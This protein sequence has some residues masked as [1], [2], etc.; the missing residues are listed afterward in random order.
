MYNNLNK[1]LQ[2]QIKRYFGSAGNVPEDL[3]G[4]LDD[5][6][7]TY[8]SRDED[9]RLFQNV[10]DVSSIE[11]RE[12]L[13][14]QRLDS[15]R[16]KQIILKIKEA[17]YTLNPLKQPV[18]AEQEDRDTSYLFDSLIGL[19]EEHKKMELSLIES[20]ARMRAITESAQDAILMMDTQGLV[21]FWNPSAERIFG[22]T[23][24]DAMGQ[25]LHDLIAPK[26]Y[27]QAHNAAFA[28][29]LK[30]GQ[31][32]AVNKLIELDACRKGGEELT[33]ELS[34]SAIHLE[35]GWHS[36]GILRDITE[37]KLAQ[38]AIQKSNKKWEAT[39]AA[40]PDGIGMISM[41]GNLQLMSDKMA[42][43]FGYNV[44]DKDQYIGKSIINFIDPSNHELLLR[45]IRKL[46]SEDSDHKI[47][48]YLA[49]RKDNSKFYIDVNS[50][51]LLDS[52]GQPESILFVGRDITERK[53]AELA[54]HESENMQRLLLD[55]LPV[56]VVII[57]PET[58]LIERVNDHVS[59]L[60]GAPAEYLV[61]Q[62]CNLLLC[63][64]GEGSCTVCDLCRDVDNSEKVMLLKD[65][66]RL[67]ILKTVKRVVL[68]GSEKLLECFVDVSI[69]KRAEYKLKESEANFRTFFESM[70]DIVMVGN[71]QGELFFTNRAATMKLGYSTG[72]LNKMNLFELYPIS[73]RS[74]ADQVF[75]E[76]LAGNKDISTL[77]LAKKDGST[78]LVETRVWFG[79]WDGKD[80]IFG[81]SKDITENKK[82][83]EDIKLQNDFYNV[84]STLSEKLIQADSDKLD[85]E[86]NNSLE[87][88]GLFNKVDK[89]YIFELNQP[90]DVMN[91]IFEWCAPG[92]EPSIEKLQNVQVT[93]FPDWK[94][95]F[96]N[97]EHIYIN[98]VS[99]LPEE[100]R[101][102]RE[103]LE[104]Q[105]VKSGGAV[106]MFYGSSLIGFIGFDSLFEEKQWKD[107]VITLLKIYANVLAG[108]INKKKTEATL[109]KA[110]QEAD[111]ASKAKSE[112]L[113][114]MSH[115]I[116]TPL[117]GIIGF[118]DL[119]MRTPLNVIQQQYAENV[120][121]SGHTLLGIINDILD[122]SKIEAGKMELELIKTDMIELIGQTSDI[123]KYHVSQKGIEFLLNIQPEMPRFAIIDP[124]RLK[125]ILINLLGNA[126][127]FTEA[128]E[129]ELMVSFIK[130]DDDTG[131]FTIHVRDTGIGIDAE[132]QK[133]LFRAFSQA[134]SSTTRKFGGTGLGLTI[135][136]M[137]AQK[138]GSIIEIISE[139]DKGSDFFFSIETAYEYGEKL[140][141]NSLSEIKSVMVI[142]DNDNNRLIL[143]HTFV[144]WGIKFIGFDNGLSAL[145]FIE[146]S[147]PLDVIIVDYHMPY[148]NGLETIGLIR[149]KLKLSPDQQPV[150]LLHSSADDLKIYE[151]CKKLG[152]KFN[153]TKPVKSQELLHYLKNIRLQSPSGEITKVKPL[154][155]EIVDISIDNAP[156]I[157]VVEDV[158]INMLLVTTSLK[159]F[160]PNVRILE[161]KNGKEAVV[162]ASS[163]KPDM[164]FMDIQM[165][166]MSGIEAT[167]EIRNF[168]KG[169][170]SHIPIVALTAGAIK[171]D[172]EKC[173]TAGMDDFMTK[174]IDQ[175]LMFSMLKKYLV[176]LSQENETT[177]QKEKGSNDHVH[178][179][180]VSL[181]ENIGNNR[182]L[183]KELIEI[184]PNQFSTDFTLLKRAID[185]NNK[186]EIKKVAH[187]LK[188]AAFSM[189]FNQLAQMT[190]EFEQD[191]NN[192]DVDGIS[193][194]YNSIMLEWEQIVMVLKELSL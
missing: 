150:V 134:D 153:L 83:E 70:D 151:E 95:A 43:I 177:G 162:T 135:S 120:N 124:Q 182:T 66:T 60:F 24:D 132:Q 163:R 38:E 97:N 64:T 35:G 34:L 140:D 54:L 17:I 154:I 18:P 143:E 53:Q 40:S 156:T 160:I 146:K 157:L 127:K 39:I 67:P 16:R 129:I 102:E 155:K 63:P 101:W 118:T 19:I 90:M 28:E 184:V 109:L 44:S 58:R 147:D 117:N 51:L 190:Q 144:N 56:G 100:R 130:K 79:Q 114:N 181:M 119:L 94:E 55:T 9:S 5:V 65:G 86:I 128:G 47:T 8:N 123:I 62:N 29:F 104:A 112:F 171:E 2:R 174:P 78:L 75:G 23:S 178:F 169:T 133:K 57:D 71:Q 14:I 30:T 6:S 189:C 141:G 26:H 125:Q 193:E 183:L 50:S 82:L 115:E 45:N 149:D 105:L 108:V 192:Y 89:A 103:I 52:K 142:D 139:P 61:G 31:G 96:L 84:I 22:Y 113:A 74:E 20:E 92:I 172:K 187:S 27:H 7:E 12:A 10:L 13:A 21:S 98:K 121:T 188:G 32:N 68:N 93:F 176:V 36:I 25:N 11:L 46:L 49:I 73:L 41:D 159:Q 185:L 87:K 180:L 161:A 37:R 145:K 106:P 15:E 110:K 1:L 138:M 168:E 72:E 99:Q 136:N 111:I 76:M 3:H 85:T 173:L 148:L 137:L 91:N 116:R 166:I 170:N 194:K 59:N 164:I 191:V 186:E 42:T 165:P 179:D 126:V 81:L 152:V 4:F 175:N 33:I 158:L 107:Q 80:C 77:P 69:Q 122:F 131:F 88:L 48:E 167:I